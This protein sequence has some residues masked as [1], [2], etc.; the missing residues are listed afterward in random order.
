MIKGL[1]QDVWVLVYM[2]RIVFA[3]IQIAFDDH[4][5][6][7][8]KIRYDIWRTEMAWD[9]VLHKAMCTCG[10]ESRKKKM[11]FLQWYPN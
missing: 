2:R 6:R 11:E 4:D 8:K 3:V 9:S 7:K 10:F 5:N 1:M